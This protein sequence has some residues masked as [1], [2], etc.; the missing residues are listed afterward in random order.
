MRNDPENKAFYPTNDR[1]IISY[2]SQRLLDLPDQVLAR[3]WSRWI[4]TN[5]DLPMSYTGVILET[6]PGYKA[7][8]LMDIQSGG[9]SS[10]GLTVGTIAVNRYALGWIRP[11]QVHVY[12]GGAQRL[13]LAAGWVNGT[14]MLVIPSDT[15]GY[16]MSLGVRVAKRHD[17]NIPKEGVEG[18]IVDQRTTACDERA[19]SDGVCHGFLRRQIPYPHD[20]ET[21]PHPD[22]ILS[23][24]VTVLAYPTKHVLAPGE[25]MEWNGVTVTVLERRGDS[26]VVEISDGTATPVVE[27]GGSGR[28]VD[29]DGNTHEADIE[30]IAELGI[31]VGCATIPDPLYCPDR[32]VSRA[33][34]AAFVA[35]AL[36]TPTPNPTTS[37]FADV[38]VGVWYAKYVHAIARLGIDTGDGDQWRPGDALTRLEMAQWLTAAYPHINPASQPDGKFGDV[39]RVDWP[40]VEGLYEAGVTYGC[41]TQPL[42]YCPDQP[43]SR[44]QMASF[45][46]RSLP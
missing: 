14:Q 40:T 42:L 45:I 28:F 26:Y 18:Y 43:V 38:N 8:N 12:Q 46:I 2:L 7:D 41:S 11:E 25:G 17:V 30:R 19:Q 10:P 1:W 36:Q 32:P 6:D 21:V 33:E 13:T 44:A 22:P 5:F 3:T 34:M 24:Y 9:N 31:T 4:G 29:D 37:S 27:E 35:R 15:Q 16:F 23:D 20:T 39:A